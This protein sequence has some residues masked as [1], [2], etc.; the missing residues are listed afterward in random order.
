MGKP[1][2]PNTQHLI[3]RFGRYPV[4]D[5]IGLELMS[6]MI[7]A[8]GGLAPARGAR[9]DLADHRAIGLLRR[10]HLDDVTVGATDWIWSLHETKSP[11]IRYAETI[12]HVFKRLKVRTRQKYRTAA[13]PHHKLGVRN[14]KLGIPPAPPQ[15]KAFRVGERHS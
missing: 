12:S 4:H 7:V 15:L 8:T 13:P 1:L 14:E 9:I 2:I 5:R 6:C 11:S 3:D 10:P